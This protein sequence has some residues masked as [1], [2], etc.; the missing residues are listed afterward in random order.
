MTVG[1]DP[2]SAFAAQMIIPTQNVVNTWNGRLPTTGN[3]NPT[4]VGAGQVD[5][6]STL[7]HEMEHSLGLA[8][9]NAATRS[10]LAGASRNFTKATDSANNVFDI[11]PGTDGII[12]SPTISAATTRTSIISGSPITTLLRPILASS[13]APPIA[14]IWRTCR[15]AILIRERRP[16]GR[17]GA[18]LRQHRSGYAARHFQRQDPAHARRRPTRD[19]DDGDFISIPALTGR[20]TKNRTSRSARPAHWRRSHLG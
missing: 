18:R 5:Y 17:R 9:V 6:E 10:G 16:C 3:L 8:H 20:S 19:H 4:G 14:A 11:N 13:T 1:I 12:G 2:T 7:L 15:S